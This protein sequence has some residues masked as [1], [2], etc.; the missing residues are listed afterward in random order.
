MLL[1]AKLQVPKWQRPWSLSLNNLPSDPLLLMLF[2]LDY[3]DLI[4]Y[5]LFGKLNSID[6]FYLAN[7]LLLSRSDKIQKVQPWKELF[8]EFYTDLAWDDLKR[9][10][11]QRRP[12]MI[13][14]LKGNIY[15]YI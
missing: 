9:Y 4:R 6:K 13:A 11:D 15:I 14:S 1:Q 12:R 5:C 7:I 2:F 8:R 10:L 3:R